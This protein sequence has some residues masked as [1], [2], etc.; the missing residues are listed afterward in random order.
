MISLHELGPIQRSV[1]EGLADGQS[2]RQLSAALGLSE[3]AIASLIRGAMGKL[4]AHS[5]TEAVVTYDRIAGGRTA[6]RGEN[7]SPG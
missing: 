3:H 4:G 2:P 6:D 7:D 1:L 5:E